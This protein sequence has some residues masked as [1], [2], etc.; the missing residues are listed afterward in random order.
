MKALIFIQSENN[1]ILRSCIES[2]YGVQKILANEND[3]IN[4]IFFDQSIQRELETYKLNTNYLISNIEKFNPLQY[5]SI[6]EKMIEEEEPDIIVFSHTYQTRDWVP[7]LSARCNISFISAM[8]S[9]C[10]TSIG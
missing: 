5:I 4:T 7:R 8:E 6:L 2:I 3:S 10:P 9:D 1:K